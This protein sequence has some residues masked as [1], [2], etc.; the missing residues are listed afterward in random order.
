M[1]ALVRVYK[2]VLEDSQLDPGKLTGTMGEPG[3]LVF[4]LSIYFQ[5][6]LLFSL[7][8]SPAFCCSR[9]ND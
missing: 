5:A 6:S 2:D 1:Y 9:T 3:R 8:L 7:A 4:R